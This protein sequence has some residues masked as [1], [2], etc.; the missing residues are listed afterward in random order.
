MKKTFRSILAGALA[1][2][3][4]S[5][6][7]DLSLREEISA[8]DER[9]TAIEETLSAEVGGVNDLLS[10]IESLEGKIAAVKLETKD[11]VT[12]LTL[13]DNSSVVLSKNGVLTIVDGGWATVAADGTV[14]PLGVPVSHDH[15][16]AFKVE[17]GELKVSYDGKTYEATG[18]KVSEYTAHV[19]G[20]VVPAADGKSVAV[21]IGDQTLQLPLVSSAVAT[22]GLSRDNFFLYHGGVKTVAITADNL[23][24]VYVMNEPAGW[25]ANIEEDNLVI[26]APKEKHVKE[27]LADE[28]GLVLVHATTEEGKCIVAKIEVSTGLGLAIECDK[29]GK[30]TISNAYTALTMDRLTGEQKFGFADFFVG[31]IDSELYGDGTEFAEMLSQGWAEGAYAYMYNLGHVFDFRAYEEVTYEVDKLETT[32]AD[33]YNVLTWG[34]ELAYGS[35]MVVWVVPTDNEGMPIA[36]ELQVVKHTHVL[37]QFEV[38]DITHNSA[39][40][41]CNIEGATR[42]YAGV[43]DG[44]YSAPL[45]TIMSEGNLWMYLQQPEYLDWWEGA[46]LPAGEYTGE[47]AI[48]LVD[49]NMGEQLN[50]G[51]K[52]Y[53]YVFPYMEGT[54]YNDFNAQFAPYVVEINTL[55]LLPGGAAA[56]T[57]GEA[58]LGYESVLVPVTLSEGTESVYYSFYSVEE[59]AELED[60]G[61]KAIFDSLVENCYWPLTY[62]GEASYDYAESGQTLVLAAV[63]VGTDGKYGEI[64]SQSYTTLALPTVKNEALTVTFGEPVIDFSSI[65]VEVTPVEGA[66]VIWYFM[67]DASLSSYE[68]D[69]EMIAFMVSRSNVITE[70]SIVKQSYLAQGSKQ[71]LVLLVL[72]AENNYNLI[73]QGYTTK[74]YPYSEAMTVECVS[75]VATG[76]PGEYTLTFNVAGASQI[77]VWSNYGGYENSFE[78]N[79]I[80]YGQTGTLANNMKVVDVVDGKATVVLAGLGNYRCLYATAISVAEGGITGLSKTPCAIPTAEL[81]VVTE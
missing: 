12:T 59:W 27:G 78:S 68:S 51:S 32:V 30:L 56:V 14:T 45:E 6:Y 29:D 8:L 39:T 4:V 18:V 62:D 54:V 11:G 21:T 7:D 60:K 58:E 25:K 41:T 77:A 72:D 66:K 40:L 10:R 5:C 26:T 55:D 69:E 67:S 31:I 3:T 74:A 43:V 44:S 28:K 57:F 9:V 75:A 63:A 16:L 36:D 48:N 53:V 23:A 64:V 33:L 22:L 35:N 49:L 24:D 19:I 17:G 38:S 46:V 1:L 15:K 71:N 79:V 42:F 2:L 81:P 70:T 20:N 73:K 47:T 50:F 37:C 80:T 65:S 34:D 52:Y 61:D 13:S 76:N